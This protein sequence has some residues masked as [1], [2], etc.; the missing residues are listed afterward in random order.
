M[1]M[2]Y[3]DNYMNTMCCT[4]LAELKIFPN[5]KEITESMAAYHVARNKIRMFDLND[6]EVVMFSVGDGRTPR[7]A[8]L[9]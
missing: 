9:L 2:K 6:P 8:A 1:S 3:I 4:D 7:T 5:A